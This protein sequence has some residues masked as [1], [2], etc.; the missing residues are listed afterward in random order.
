MQYPTLTEQATTR[1]MIDVFRGYNHNL[2]IGDGE[3]YDMKNLTSAHYPVLSPREARGLYASPSSAQGLIA[4][5][6][7]CYVDGPDFVMNGYPIHMGLSTA[8]EDCPKKLV[9]MGAYVIILPDKMWINTASKPEEPQFG[10]IEA[11]HVSSDNV[12]FELCTIEGSPY[13]ATPSASAPTD[14]ENMTL[15]ID[16]S[17]K[18]HAL[19]QYSS[20]SSTWVS[21]PTTYIRIYS[22]GI[23]KA[24][25][26]YD[27]VTISGVKDERLQDL[28]ASMVIWAKGE[29]YIVVTGMLD[30]KIIQS[31][32]EDGAI[33]F[34]RKMPEMDFIV[35]SGNRLWGCR[36]GPTA[37]GQVVNEVYASKL[38]DFKNWNCFMGVSTD[39]YA[40][41][42]GT[43]GQF[44]GAITHLG[45]PI[46][47]KENCLHKVY[48][49][50]PSNFQIQTTACRGVQRG[51][52]KSLAIVNEVLYY[53]STQAVCAYDGSLPTEIS[54]ALGEVQYGNA[55]AGGHGNRYYISMQDAAG[56]YHLFC[57]DAAKGMWHKED[58]THADAFCSARDVMYYID[59]E[60]GSI[61]TIAGGD[62]IVEWM[63]E[64]GVIG[65][66][67]PDQK[68]V[69]RILL[70][71]A[72]AMGSTV[73]VYAQYDSIGVW[74]SVCVLTGTSLRSFTIPIRPKRCDHMRLRIEG[75]GEA[76]LYSITKTIEQGS[77]F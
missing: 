18:P 14:P 1:Q 16:T 75:E 47:F 72:L 38:G 65:I 24:F 61:K 53:K 3:F 27:G 13:N 8:E 37:N 69:S 40:A 64:T 70:R 68:Y 33:R 48:G 22:T 10:K 66:T 9:S 44:T 29:N 5:D 74:E 60:D 20:V 55:V 39:S 58:N 6:T 50:F 77:D 34:E 57:Y 25:E 21:I 17:S 41:S 32:E 59:H 11:E 15:W 19:K 46:F 43:D 51:S 4:K 71:M 26:Q 36:Y 56:A 7:I 76:K 49:N 35:E 63:A 31:S 2:R 73:R 45:Y 62:G 12:T 54:S 42:L 52:E 67:I 28:N 30:G 23:D